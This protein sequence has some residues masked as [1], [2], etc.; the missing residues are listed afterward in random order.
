VAIRGVEDALFGPVISYG[1]SGAATDLLGDCAY[2]IPPLHTADAAEMVREIKA[3]PLLFGYRGSAP[4]DIA[5][6]ERLLLK[7]AQLKDDLPEVRELD[8]SLVSVGTSGV[9]VLTAAGT[10]APAV[11]ARSD[12]FARRMAR[13]VGDTNAG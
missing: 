1:I 13:P 11:E 2:R 3:A 6:L 10:V 8:L 12:W 7:V 4:V 9:T 5:A